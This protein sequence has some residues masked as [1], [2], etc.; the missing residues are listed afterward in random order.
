MIHCLFL[1]HARNWGD[2]CAESPPNSLICAVTRNWRL[3]HVPDGSLDCFGHFQW[4]RGPRGVLSTEY[5][6]F[7][8]HLRGVDRVVNARG[9]RNDPFHAKRCK[10]LLFR[11]QRDLYPFGKISSNQQGHLQ[12]QMSCRGRAILRF[13]I[14]APPTS[15]T[16][17]R[18]DENE[19]YLPCIAIQLLRGPR[20]IMT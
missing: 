20:K 8:M 18:R 3:H 9:A 16:T 17:T 12:A 7:F 14:L 4:A 19:P 6:A 10:L 13:G 5:E 11:V 1:A 15:P 2:V